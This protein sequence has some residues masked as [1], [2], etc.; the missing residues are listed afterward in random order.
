M[1]TYTYQ[2]RYLAHTVRGGRVTIPDQFARNQRDYD[3]KT[4]PVRRLDGSAV[5]ATLRGDLY[6][7]HTPG[8]GDPIVSVTCGA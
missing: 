4:F 2:L 6:G 3:G 7:L 1:A 5:R 8:I